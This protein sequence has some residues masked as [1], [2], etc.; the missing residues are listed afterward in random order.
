MPRESPSQ[1]K[2]KIEDLYRKVDST[3]DTEQIREH[4]KKIV[5]LEGKLQKVSEARDK[6]RDTRHRM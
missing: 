2:A 4:G 5:E 1:I 6:K 3:T